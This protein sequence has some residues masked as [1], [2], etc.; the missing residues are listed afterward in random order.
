[1]SFKSFMEKFKE[2]E[3]EDFKVLLAIES[4]MKNYEYVPFEKIVEYSKLPI[5]KVEYR[6]NRV[7]RLRLVRSIT[8]PY[9]GYCLNYIGYDFLALR[10][11]VNSGF[12]EAVGGPLGVGKEADVYEALTPEGDV[13]ALKFHRLG[14]I[15][16]RQTAKVRSYGK[17]KTFW[18]FRS[19]I[20]AE[21]EY[22]ALKKLYSY[23]VSVPKP[24]SQNRHAVLMGKIEGIR[25]IE[26]KHLKDPEN[27]FLKILE[28][29]KLAYRKAGVIHADLSEY[30]V[31][32]DEEERN[33]QIIDWPQYVTINHPNAQQILERDLKNISKFFKRKFNLEISFKDVLDFVVLGKPVKKVQIFLQ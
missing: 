3:A 23:G 5:D 17:P 15:S 25:L 33:I 10:F 7:S 13:A 24:I 28:N 20:A 19:K 31:L 6:V 4:G 21:K 29:V 16:F 32:L 14:R 9:R 8:S 12:L 1:M 27:V 11:F 18:L 26:F 22:E 2:I 30:N